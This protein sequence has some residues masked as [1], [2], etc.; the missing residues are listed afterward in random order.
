[1]QIVQKYADQISQEHQLP[2]VDPEEMAVFCRNSFN[3]QVL[4]SSGGIKGEFEI[5]ST[6]IA[7]DANQN[8]DSDV[9]YYVLLRALDRF[10][11]LNGQ[12]PG[13][14][15]SKF[16]NDKFAFKSLLAAF[17]KEYGITQNIF[18]N[19]TEEM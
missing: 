9:V 4:S 3:L 10:R 5:P 15:D 1:L 19:Q 16:E 8:A 13:I 2:S 7:D 14:D 12:F 6:A 17:L 18:E 11:S